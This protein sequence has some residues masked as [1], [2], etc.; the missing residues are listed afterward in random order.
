M[1]NLTK[2]S[3]EVPMPSLLTIVKWVWNVICIV[4][5][6]T[7]IYF[8][9]QIKPIKDDLKSQRE[10]HKI[11]RDSMET[12]LNVLEVL[13]EDKENNV[14][15]I[16]K[17]LDKSKRLIS[18]TEEELL[19][20]ITSMENQRKQKESILVQKDVKLSDKK[21]EIFLNNRFPRKNK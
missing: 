20:L 19:E 4:A 6:G 17:E 12:N 16:N 1:I 3:V 9:I 8:Y 10:K 13:I 5:L 11:Y 7:C 21:R 14:K 15:K 18:K 2:S